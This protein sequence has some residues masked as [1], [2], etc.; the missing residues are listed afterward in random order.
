MGDTKSAKGPTSRRESVLAADIK[1]TCV[2]VAASVL[3]EY[4]GRERTI[5]P[6]LDITVSLLPASK[7]APPNDTDR[8]NSQNPES[9][10]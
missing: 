2:A 8:V 1:R 10:T 9:R 6:I 4:D 5:V 7:L 3:E